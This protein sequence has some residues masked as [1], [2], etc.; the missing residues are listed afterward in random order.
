MLQEAEFYDQTLQVAPDVVTNRQTMPVV[1]D[2]TRELFQ[3]G[4]A[5]DAAL[6]CGW[7]SYGP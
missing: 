1:V 6:Y 3:P 5:P 2:E 7:Y 4:E